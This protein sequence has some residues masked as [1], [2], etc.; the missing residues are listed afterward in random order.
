VIDRQQFVEAAVK[1]F[2]ALEA[3]IRDETWVGLVHL[4]VS[5]FARYTQQQIDA[6]DRIELKRCFEFARRVL[7][8]GTPDL[9]NAM[10]VSYLEHLNM[11]DQRRSRSWALK[12]MPENLRLEFEAVTGRRSA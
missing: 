2:P 8:D 5:A 6:E 3:D 4:E 9:K 7:L 11:R 12:E 1:A 10:A